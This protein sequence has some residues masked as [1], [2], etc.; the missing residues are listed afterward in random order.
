MAHSIWREAWII[1][2]MT[3]MVTTIQLA[4]CGL[5]ALLDTKTPAIF[6]KW[7][8]WVAIWTGLSFLPLTFIPFFN[9]GP[10]AINGVWNFYVVFV[11][12][13]VWF[14]SYSYF[15]FKDVKRVRV[16]PAPA[17]AQAVSFGHAE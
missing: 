5:F 2:D 14:T 1:Y 3:Y 16:S 17:L 6:P 13:G 9:D 12:W 15:M 4:G 10:I 8:G 7:A 11:S